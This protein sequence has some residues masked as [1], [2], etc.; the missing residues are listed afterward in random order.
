MPLAVHA[1]SQNNCVPQ[2]R[3]RH[4]TKSLRDQVRRRGGHLRRHAGNH[5]HEHKA[6]ASQRH[7]QARFLHS[8]TGGSMRFPV[9]KLPVHVHLVVNLITSIRTAK[10]TLASAVAQ[11]RSSRWIW[12]LIQLNYFT[13][14][15]RP[16]LFCFYCCLFL[17]CAGIN[18]YSLFFIINS[19]PCR[20][21]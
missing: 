18:Y 2:L 12:P 16:K 15:F 11:S 14:S 19:P 5:K 8:T 17:Y 21:I 7:L 10:L 6:T 13:G 4:R 3:P 1:E 9:A 20:I